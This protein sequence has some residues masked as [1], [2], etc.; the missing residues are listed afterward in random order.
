MLAQDLRVEDVFEHDDH[1]YVLL[2]EQPEVRVQEQPLVQSVAQWKAFSRHLVNAMYEQCN[3]DILN[4]EGLEILTVLSLLP[5]VDCR[6][7]ALK[8]LTSILTS[9]RSYFEG[10]SDAFAMTWMLKLCTVD[11]D[12]EIQLLCAQLLQT[13]VRGPRFGM[14]DG[15][16][17]GR[18]A[19]LRLTRSDSEKV[20]KLALDAV[21][22]LSS[23]SPVGHNADGGLNSEHKRKVGNR[24][25][26][27][28]RFDTAEDAMEM[29]QSKES[30]QLKE[31]ALEYFSRLSSAFDWHS[32]LERHEQDFFLALF[33]VGRRDPSLAKMVAQ[34]LQTLTFEPKICA[35]LFRYDSLHFLD[36]QMFY[37]E[38][39]FTR[40]SFSSVIHDLLY[41]PIPPPIQSVVGLLTTTRNDTTK[42]DVAEALA[43]RAK[44]D[45]EENELGEFLSELVME[46]F[47]ALNFSDLK[48]TNHLVQTIATVSTIAE[49]QI[50][51]HTHNGASVLVQVLDFGHRL[52]QNTDTHVVIRM[53]RAAAKALANLSCSLSL[54]QSQ[55]FQRAM[56]NLPRADS[57]HDGAVRMYLDMVLINM[58]SKPTRTRV[59][60]QSGL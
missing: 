6:E 7:A 59:S 24:R 34:I 23:S 53:Q 27:V 22:Y 11:Q 48:L 42:L 39:V 14:I 47:E 13:L 54:S 35:A 3:Q 56:L 10:G 49:N 8:L 12:P 25:E 4:N 17:D 37:E 43:R 44:D 29:L 46:T 9:E 52:P 51:L 2:K 40:S 28:K 32:F 21:R 16:E 57:F 58:K 45:S 36:T 18:S 33:A 26:G 19:L 5:T 38:D 50:K 1:V 15:D 41:C 31:Y 55:P 20:K 60:D 30:I